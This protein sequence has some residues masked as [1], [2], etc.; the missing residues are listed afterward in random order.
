M[1]KFFRSFGGSSK[2]GIDRSDSAIQPSGMIEGF[3]ASTETLK[4]LNND[5]DAVSVETADTIPS[6]AKSEAS[7]WSEISAVNSVNDLRIDS[8]ISETVDSPIRC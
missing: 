6:Q 7:D 5:D 8:K 1:R 4:A 3:R 2:D